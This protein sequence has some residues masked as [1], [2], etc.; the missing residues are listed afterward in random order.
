MK[1]IVSEKKG[2]HGK[3]LIVTDCE[4]IGQK[5]EEGKL[6]ID[7][8]Q[9]F[10]QGEERSEEEVKQIVKGAQHLHLTGK[11]AVALGIS[12]ELIE[13]DKIIYI[14]NIPHAEMVVGQ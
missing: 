2:P 6:Q 4:I 9:K 5:F 11:N 12:L 10:Y 3:L 7:L 1:Y 8:T 13:S 14:K